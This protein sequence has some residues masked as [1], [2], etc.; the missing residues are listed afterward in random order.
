MTARW[1]PILVLLA[2]VAL[3]LTPTAASGGCAGPYVT[4]V[5]EHENL[6]ATGGGWATGCQ[7]TCS[8]TLGCS[9]ESCD[10]G[11]DPVPIEQVTLQLVDAEGAVLL[12]RTVQT[13]DG[14]FTVSLPT[15]PGAFQLLAGGGGVGAAHLLAAPTSAPTSAP[16]PRS[17]P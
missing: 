8:C 2:A 17:T 14:G 1:H 16:T 9:G 12:E 3:T 7:D 15:V 4:A 13:T 6:I 11:P 5:A 10:C